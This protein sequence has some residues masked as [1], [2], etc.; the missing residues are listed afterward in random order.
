MSKQKTEQELQKALALEIAKEYCEQHNLSI[1]KLKRQLFNII[2]SSAIF[3]QPS[4]VIPDGLLNDLETQPKPTLIIKLDNNR[5]N[6]IETEHTAKYL[7]I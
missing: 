1:D 7:S 2:Y 4:D 6:V 3:A 5:L